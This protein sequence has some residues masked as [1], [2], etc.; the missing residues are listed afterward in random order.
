MGK[1]RS[2][3]KEKSFGGYSF[4]QSNYNLNKYLKNKRERENLEKAGFKICNTTLKAAM[5]Q[6]KRMNKKREKWIFQDNHNGVNFNTT[7]WNN[8]GLVFST[9]GRLE[10]K[11]KFKDGQLHI[12]SKAMKSS[13]QYFNVYVFVNSNRDIV[14]TVWYLM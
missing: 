3:A 14:K 8:K 13:G 10:K 9:F 4:Y 2:N 6:E 11:Y 1:L 12:Y 5:I 7:G